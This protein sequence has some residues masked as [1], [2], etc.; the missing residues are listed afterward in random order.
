MLMVSFRLLQ[1]LCGRTFRPQL[2]SYDCS[3]QVDHWHKWNAL[4]P[5]ARSLIFT[6]RVA[7]SRKKDRFV[8]SSETTDRIT[9]QHRRGPQA[10][11]QHP[12]PQLT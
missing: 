4:I 11:L 9:M 5:I 8:S 1:F 2:Y 12:M 7:C 10:I 3:F 6:M